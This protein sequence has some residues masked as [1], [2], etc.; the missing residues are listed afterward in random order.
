LIL[1]LKQSITPGD[2]RIYREA[3]IENNASTLGADTARRT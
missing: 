1:H 2:R 3:L